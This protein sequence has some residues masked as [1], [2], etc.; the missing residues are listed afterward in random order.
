MHDAAAV[1]VGHDTGQLSNDTGRFARRW[2]AVFEYLFKI[3][4]GNVFQNQIRAAV[5]DPGI[6][7]PHEAGV[8]E[9]GQKP[10]FGHQRV[11]QAI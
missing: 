5:V 4:A 6:E 10:T 8:V 9:F 2:L 7:N 11:R 1:R 3:F